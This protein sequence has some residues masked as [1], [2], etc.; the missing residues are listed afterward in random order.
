MA[1]IAPNFLNTGLH[2]A[3]ES[4]L[5]CQLPQAARGPYLVAFNVNQGTSSRV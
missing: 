3:R 1:P 2:L 4:L 5:L